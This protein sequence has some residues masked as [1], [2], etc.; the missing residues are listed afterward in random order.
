MGTSA[1]SLFQSVI[2]GFGIGIVISLVWAVNFRLW[3]KLHSIK[4]FVAEICRITSYLV[5]VCIVG[6]SSFTI[7]E[8]VFSPPDGMAGLIHLVLMLSVALSIIFLGTRVGLI[9]DQKK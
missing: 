9:P 1:S 7:I 2:S 3:N 8:G 4:G 6:F 5:G